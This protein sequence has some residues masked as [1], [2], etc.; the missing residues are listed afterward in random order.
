MVRKAHSHL[1][2]KISSSMPS[3][4]RSNLQSCWEYLAA[5]STW[6]YTKLTGTY[7]PSDP[8]GPTRA[9]RFGSSLV[10]R[11]FTMAQASR[12][13][14]RQADIFHNRICH[15][16]PL[17]SF[18]S[19]SIL[20]GGEADGHKALATLRITSRACS[21]TRDSP[22]SRSLDDPDT[23]SSGRPVNIP[24]IIAISVSPIAELLSK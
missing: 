4:R 16:A 17:Y 18:T 10:Y 14:S 23:S 13:P 24:A 20:P 2:S 6:S 8:R 19:S 7:F 22:C 15:R 5:T 21:C 1:D 12:A 9:M 11:V 3:S